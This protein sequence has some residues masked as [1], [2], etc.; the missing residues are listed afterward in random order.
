VRQDARRSI[1]SRVAAAPASAAGQRVVQPS[2]DSTTAGARR[3]RPLPVRI[4][5]RG[6]AD[7][8]PAAYLGHSSVC[9]TGSTLGSFA[10]STEASDT[11][12][13]PPPRDDKP[14]PAIRRV[15]TYQ[16]RTSTHKPDPAS[17]GRTAVASLAAGA[18]ERVARRQSGVM[19][20]GLIPSNATRP[21]AIGDH[22]A[23]G[24]PHTH[25]A[26]PPRPNWAG[27]PATESVRP[28]IHCPST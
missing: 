24:R 9:R 21:V 17:L 23:T 19:G 25:P 27:R 14:G 1:G 2:H 16:D 12:L 4:V 3:A 8:T 13:G 10:S 11:P 15:G 5:S 18:P 22:A 26:T 7:T 28:P 20:A 6:S